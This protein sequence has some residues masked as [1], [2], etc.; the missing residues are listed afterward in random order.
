V[1]ATP[2]PWGPIVKIGCQHLLLSE[3]RKKWKHLA[4]IYEVDVTET[5]VDAL[6]AKA[7]AITSRRTNRSA[8]S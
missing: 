6:I 1:E 7:E 5:Q 3:W 2:T 4:R 8:E